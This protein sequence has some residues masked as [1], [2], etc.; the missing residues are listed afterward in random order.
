MKGKAKQTFRKTSR[1][2]YIRRFPS[3]LHG[4]DVKILSYTVPEE[5]S[6]DRYLYRLFLQDFDLLFIDHYGHA[7]INVCGK[8]VNL[9]KDQIAAQLNG[10]Y[11]KEDA[12]K[13]IDFLLSVG[14][15]RTDENGCI[16]HP[17]SPVFEGSGKE[18][19]SDQ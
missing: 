11:R 16:W 12:I 10:I 15:L 2:F 17:L 4:E 1:G 5:K 14:L 8:P 3:E 6:M 7:S 19:E 9:S 18:E 13:A